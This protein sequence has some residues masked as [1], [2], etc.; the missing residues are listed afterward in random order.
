[1]APPAPEDLSALAR[2]IVARLQQAGFTAY[3]AGGCVRDRL[4]GRPPKD[5]DVA[6][7]ATPDQIEALFPHTKPVGRAF[8]VI[9]V[10][11]GVQAVE[12]ATFRREAGYSDGRRP[13]T[14]QFASAEED[15]ARRD[16][17]INGMF[18]DPIADRTHDFVGGQADLERRMIRAIGSP[19]DRFAED[20]LRLL[21]AI[22]FA[23]V[24]DFDVDPATMAAIREHAPLLARIAPERIQQE[25]TRLLTESP[26]P[27]RGL[28][29]LDESGLLSVVLPE[30]AAMKGVEQPPEFHPEGDVF[31]HTALM[32][33]LLDR[34]TPELAYAVLFHDVGKP[35][36]FRRTTRPDGSERIRFDGHDRVGADMTVRIMQR[37]RFPNAL[38]EAVAHCVRNHMRFIA[39]PEMRDAT[40]RKL[41]GAPTFPIEL[42]LHRVDCLGSHRD[43]RNYEAL[44]AF[45]ARIRDEPVLPDPIINGHD[46]M[47]LGVPEG[48][49]VGR[50][51]KRAYEA[52]LEGRFSSR[53][54][55][56]AWIRRERSQAG[57]SDA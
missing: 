26:R 37:L 33:D 47:A 46:I 17:T 23:S 41:V 54:E 57:D 6:T 20:H 53:E 4:M 39:V 5:Y 48:P 10:I 34:P 36:T 42:E 55:G 43:L 11:E 40:L 16:F 32:L 18:Y 25:L 52:Q 31:T 30:V 9:L 12:V 45:Q 19:R 3:W 21:R 38:T 29:L 22:R 2:G 24:L 56:L 28:R 15:A 27:G 49:A 8:G 13:D 44:T 50:W 7:S 1:M 14:V 51:H 35:P